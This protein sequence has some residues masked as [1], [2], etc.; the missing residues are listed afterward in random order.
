MAFETGMM[1]ESKLAKKAQHDEFTA[2]LR[3]RIRFIM[4]A[5]PRSIQQLSRE[6]GVSMDLIRSFLMDLRQTNYKSLC[7]FES[8]IEKEEA[9]IK[10][11]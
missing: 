7:I 8:W 5:N 1:H 9:S 4:K 10:K 2:N 6:L 11:G 3:S